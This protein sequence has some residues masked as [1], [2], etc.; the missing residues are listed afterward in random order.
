MAL[1]LTSPS[2][3]A[4]AS[5][6]GARKRL[7][8]AAYELFASRGVRAVGIDTIIQRS[9]VARQT[10][11]RHFDSKQALAFAWLPPRATS[12]RPGVPG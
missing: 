9:G 8:E 1:P 3:R 10:M 2:A 4:P 7:L 5:A 6:T 12:T 11:Y